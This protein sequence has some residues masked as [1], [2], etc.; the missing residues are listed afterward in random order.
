MVIKMVIVKLNISARERKR[1]KTFASG[2]LYCA[3]D[4]YSV[5]KEIVKMDKVFVV[6]R[7]HPLG[8]L[9][10]YNIQSTEEKAIEWID[11]YG[12]H[13]TFI[14]EEYQVH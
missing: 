6:F 5:V 2:A 14:Y 13:G 7:V 3:L 1:Y 8:E 10:M 4:T 12:N 9:E 11:K